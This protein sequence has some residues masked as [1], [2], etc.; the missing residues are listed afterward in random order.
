MAWG[1][2]D[3]RLG[4]VTDPIDDDE[5]GRRKAERDADREARA[6]ERAERLALLREA[7]LQAEYATGEMEDTPE[8]ARRHIIIRVGTI[9]V[10][11]IVLLG[12][13]AM[14]VLPGPGIVG[15]LA[16]LGILSRELAWAERMIEYVKKR[17]KVEELQQQPK[18]VQVAMWTFTIAAVSSSLIYFTVLR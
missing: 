11:F 13:L 9:V 18:W 1:D 14:M 2:E 12:G 4:D 3:G 6:S 10:G 17:A 5:R 7:A 15:I 16:G 8:E